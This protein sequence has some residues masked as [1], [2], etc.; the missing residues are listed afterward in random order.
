MY[1]NNNDNPCHLLI[2]DIEEQLFDSALIAKPIRQIRPSLPLIL[3]R[4]PGQTEN[5]EHIALFNY[6][7]KKP[8]NPEQLLSMLNA[9]LSSEEMGELH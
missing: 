4:A 5:E 1:L 9:V 3:L 7:L 2:L 6:C 8:I